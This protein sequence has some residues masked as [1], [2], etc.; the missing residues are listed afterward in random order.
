MEVQK[1]E[2][3][4]AESFCLSVNFEQNLTSPHKLFQSISN[5]ILEFQE[6]DKALVKCID[7]QIEPIFVLDEVEKGSIKIWLKQI[8]KSLPDEAIGELDA[9]KLLGDYLVRGKYKILEKMGET[10]VVTDPKQ[11]ENLTTDLKI[12]A[13]QYNFL[14]PETTSGIDSL[15]LLST[16]NNISRIAGQLPADSTFT[17]LSD[18]PALDINK[19]FEIPQNCIDIIL[20]NQHID[21]HSIMIIKVKQPDYL[22]SAQWIFRYDGKALPCSIDDEEWIRKFHSRKIDI[23]PGDSLKVEMDIRSSYDKNNELLSQKYTIKKVLE[24]INMIEVEQIE[25]KTISPE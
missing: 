14:I 3:I 7:S 6:L 20:E 1:T 9:K 23:R 24:V 12:L 8:L 18:E 15:K 13:Q 25:M 16:M 5:M 11:I 19:K 22:G 21:N 4:N 2:T 17:Y 10:E